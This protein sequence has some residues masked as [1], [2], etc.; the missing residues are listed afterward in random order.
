MDKCCAVVEIERLVLVRLNELERRLDR[1]LRI[2]MGKRLL[3]VSPVDMLR[4]G[5][6]TLD[7]IL[8]IPG[9]TDEVI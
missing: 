2:V 4:P 7:Q 6:A 3:Q 9:K 1:P 8:P 5:K